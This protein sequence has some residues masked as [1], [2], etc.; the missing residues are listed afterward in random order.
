MAILIGPTF[1]IENLLVVILHLRVSLLFLLL[2]HQLVLLAFRVLILHVFY[3]EQ[4]T[5]LMGLALRTP[6]EPSRRINLP[7]EMVGVF[8]VVGH[9]G[10][11]NLEKGC[12]SLVRV[13]P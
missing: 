11:T 4:E 8:K 12:P 13:S 5:W 9:L 10:R 7:T 2:V 3:F 6:S 1:Q